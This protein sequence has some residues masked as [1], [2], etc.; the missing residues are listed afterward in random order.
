MA[1]IECP[2]CERKISTS[3]LACPGCGAPAHQPEKP[4]AEPVTTTQS[5]AKNLK[6][7][8]AIAVIISII[9]AIMTFGTGGDSTPGIIMLVAGVLFTIIVKSRIWWHHD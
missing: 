5:T 8:Y 7:Q 6:G 1:L 2:D 9:G 3:A 4:A